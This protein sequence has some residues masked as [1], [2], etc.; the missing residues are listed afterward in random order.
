MQT[1]QQY[2]VSIPYRYATNGAP[3]WSGGYTSP[4]S[5]PYRYAT[6]PMSQWLEECRWLLFQ[7]L[8]G[9]LQTDESFPDHRVIL[10]FQF[11]I[12]TLQTGCGQRGEQ[13]CRGFNSL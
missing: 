1:Q 2:L 3:G 5:I 6:N 9:T 10:K 13:G 11:L 7:F 12:G 4:V 8:I